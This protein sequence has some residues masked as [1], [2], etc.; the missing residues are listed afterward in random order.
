MAD[1]L[2]DSSRGSTSVSEDENF[3]PEEF[4][5]RPHGGKAF[6]QRQPDP[7]WAT[8]ADITTMV[9]DLK[10]FFASEMGSEAD[11]STLKTDLSTLAGRIKATEEETQSLRLKQASTNT[12]EVSDTYPA[13]SG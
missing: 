8:K 2:P 5:T 4:L 9:T 6:S 3:D 13:L 11:L 12:Q 1:T 7:Q 10:A